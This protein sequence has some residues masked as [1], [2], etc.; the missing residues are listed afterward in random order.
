M[1]EGVSILQ[2]AL[3]ALKLLS[4]LVAL[5][6]FLATVGWLRGADNIALPGL[7]LIIATPLL[8]VMMAVALIAVIIAAM[9]M[10]AVLK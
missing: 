1:A 5:V 8:I 7:G 6:L 9:V 2:M 4:V 3:M 10:S